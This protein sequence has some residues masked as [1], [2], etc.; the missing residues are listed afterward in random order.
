MN[1]AR[2]HHTLVKLADGTVLAVG[3]STT[4]NQDA[5][6]TPGATPAPSIGT[7]VRTVRLAATVV[8]ANGA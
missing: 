3:G 7:G 8:V 1:N 2:I 4:S 6:V 5:I